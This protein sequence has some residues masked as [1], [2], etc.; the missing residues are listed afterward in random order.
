MELE[1][2]MQVLRTKVRLSDI[3]KALEV[4]KRVQPLAYAIFVKEIE[5]RAK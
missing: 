5:K 4:M 2:L 3:R 1:D